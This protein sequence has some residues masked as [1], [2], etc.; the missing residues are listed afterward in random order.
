MAAYPVRMISI[1]RSVSGES[2]SFIYRRMPLKLVFAYEHAY[3]EENDVPVVR[4]NAGSGDSDDALADL[5]RT[6]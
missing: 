2:A 4:Y 6:L 3:Y 5:L 1:V